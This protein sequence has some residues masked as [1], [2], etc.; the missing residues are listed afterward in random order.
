MK[1]N[2]CIIG[3][4]TSF[5]KRIL[6]ALA[7]KLDMLYADV[8]EMLEFDLIDVVEAREKTSAS[9]IDGLE[10]KKIKELSTF[11]NVIVGMDYQ[12][13]MKGNNSQV[14]L[15][16]YYVLFLNLNEPTFIRTGR[17]P[18]EYTVYAIKQRYARRFRQSGCKQSNQQDY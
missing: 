1:N 13:F 18:R 3:L 15:N 14:A 11:D 16:N 4:T 5:T 9:Y 10:T 2:L 6:N 8:N 17:V 7:T 12:T